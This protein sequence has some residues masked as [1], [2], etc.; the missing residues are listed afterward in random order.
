MLPLP[1]VLSNRPFQMY[2]GPLLM[3]AEWVFACTV[4]PWPLS[5]RRGQT[6]SAQVF[7]TNVGHFPREAHPIWKVSLLN[8]D[9][10]EMR[11][12]LENWIWILIFSKLLILSL[13]WTQGRPMTWP[14]ST[15]PSEVRIGQWIMKEQD[16]GKSEASYAP[17]VYIDDAG[18]IF[19]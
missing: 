3:Y 17:S 7:G 19:D 5:D 8:T 1:L 15:L 18:S 2:S 11:T 9:D 6:N 10:M 12:S 16:K 14:P 4:S 13:H